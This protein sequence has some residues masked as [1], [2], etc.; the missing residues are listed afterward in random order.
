MSINAEINP[1]ARIVAKHVTLHNV[2]KTDVG[3][4]NVDNTS[5]INKPIS[6][7]T[8]TALD[9]K[10]NQS[11]TYTKTEV[12]A[13][14]ENLVAGAPG[15]LD[16]LNELAAALGDNTNFAS[17]T[18]TSIGQKLAKASNLSDLANATIARINL[19]LGTAATT[20][21]SDYATAA[22]GTSADNALVASAVSTFG[23]TLIDDADAATARTTLGLGTAATTASSDY[24]PAAGSS[25]I[26]TVGTL[27]DLTVDGN[28]RSLTPYGYGTYGELKT[29]NGD[30]V[31]LGIGNVNS[32]D[33]FVVLSSE[34]G[35]TSSSETDLTAGNGVLSLRGGAGVTV[36]DNLTASE[37]L[38]VEENLTVDGNLTV[39]PL[40][41]D[42]NTFVVDS[43]NDLVGINCPNGPTAPLEVVGDVKIIGPTYPGTGRPVIHLQKP[44]D[45]SADNAGLLFNEQTRLTLGADDTKNPFEI[46]TYST[47][48]FVSNDYRI[49]KDTAGASKHEFR[50]G[51]SNK[52]EINSDGIGINK[53]PE[54]QLDM[55]GNF[56]LLI[57]PEKRVSGQPPALI[58]STD[59]TG[60]PLRVEGPVTVTHD[61]FKI[62]GVDN[63]FGDNSNHFHNITRINRIKQHVAENPTSEAANIERVQEKYYAIAN[64]N[65][66]NNQ[67][68]FLNWHRVTRKIKSN[69]VSL[70]N[71]TGWDVSAIQ[72][73]DYDASARPNGRTQ[74]EQAIFSESEDTTFTF[75]S[76]N[77]PLAL[78]DL[79]QIK[80][81]IEFAGA[82]VA[83]THFAKVTAGATTTTTT[84]GLVDGLTITSTQ[85]PYA[86]VGTFSNRP[87]NN[88]G[89]GAGTG[90][91]LRLNV[92][93]AAVSGGGYT[94][95]FTI[96]DAGTGYNVG[97]TLRI[98]GGYLSSS[99]GSDDDD[100]EDVFLTVSSITTGTTTTTNSDTSTVVLYGGSYKSL[101][102]VPDGNSQTALTTNF[103]VSKI[104]TSAYMTLASGNNIDVLTD[105]TRA[106][107]TDTFKLTFAG[108]HN[109]DLND[110]ITVIT[111]GSGNFQEAESAFVKE[112][113][114]TTEA[115]F[116]YGRGFEPSDTFSNLADISGSAVVGILKGSL[117]GIHRETSGDLLMQFNSDNEGRYKGYQIGPGSEIGVANCIS[118]GKNVYNKDASTIKI[119]YDNE[120][121]DVRSDGVVVAGDIEASGSVTGATLVGTLST[122][123]QPNITSLGNLTSLACSGS[124]LADNDITTSN[125][126][127][128]HIDTTTLAV[129]GNLTIGGDLT[130]NGTT[131][132]INTTNLD[133]DDNLI[134][135]NRGIDSSSANPNDIGFIF[136]RGTSGDN[137]AIL[138]DESQ[139]LFLFG[140][141]TTDASNS[142]AANN[143]LAA[144][145]VVSEISSG[146]II[147]RDV[148]ANVDREIY[149]ENNKFFG[150]NH[151]VAGFSVG[152]DEKKG[153]VIGLDTNDGNDLDISAPN[154][155][156]LTPGGNV[157]IGTAAASVLVDVTG[158]LVT[159]A[160]ITAGTSLTAPQLVTNEIQ[161]VASGTDPNNAVPI[162]YDAAEHRFRDFDASPTNLMVIKKIK[163][164]NGAR[165]GINV[166]ANQNPKCA[167]HVSYGGSSDGL[168]RE[169]LRVTGGAMFN[170]WVR[171]GHFTDTERDNL[172][173]PTNGTII[174]NDTHHEFQA[175]IGGAQ[176]AASRWQAFAMQNVST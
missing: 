58:K 128:S 40:Q 95:T 131:T 87:V 143:Y 134:T 149:F 118:I 29:A 163:G 53:T 81:D 70:T 127:F 65:L 123:A 79:L 176:G 138:W 92:T 173:N 1:S 151:I 164:K 74:T 78:G 83:A 47:G 132:T 73:F 85:N 126:Y 12:D 22:Q 13:N 66:K 155:I 55:D 130:V 109:L 41:G 157:S 24:A 146:K 156:T 169:A 25:S 144:K 51:N 98:Y 141:S 117:D 21:S 90:S 168:P 15:Q 68:A 145:I 113:V 64:N 100:I 35:Y 152:L 104:D 4:E 72:D 171:I 32:G 84:T 137:A 27:T 105:N 135:L 150:G 38:T 139:D 114:S 54:R 48:V 175:Y 44:Y 122:A 101:D 67:A 39:G 166:P 59:K 159:S 8:Q 62:S 34:N 91:G 69:S 174:Y 75:T 63:G 77:N 93:V 18:T 97:D 7:A 10:A 11:T 17:T 106:N 94:T 31:I 43:V 57:S 116:V 9:L 154:D 19:G 136:E 82:I 172:S 170:E 5:D 86:E 158:N 153:D 111:D 88:Y 115:I 6:N 107:P 23:G 80:I 16:T 165:V 121:L 52:L 2:S 20:A 108:D 133:I 50:I 46:Q 162:H 3:L 37:N 147:L 119:G 120:M 45:E 26:T 112:V 42:A 110:N 142:G 60:T 103:S 30:K 71:L 148:P 49:E 99:G 160:S 89:A 61:L 56:R 124:I 129:G 33:N 161:C 96:A 140:T 36:S 28:I 125:G 102:E 167:L 76:G 14:I